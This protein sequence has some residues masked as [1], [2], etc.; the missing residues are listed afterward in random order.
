MQITTTITYL[1]P[2][3]K[4]S[5]I[6]GAYRTYNIEL[7]WKDTTEVFYLAAKGASTL[8]CPSLKTEIDYDYTLGQMKDYYYD[9]S[10]REAKVF[11]SK[12][13]AENYLKS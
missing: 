2:D 6:Y 12:Q 5:G 4:L 11:K 8:L 10:G 1:N 7:P 13:E 3:C 9:W